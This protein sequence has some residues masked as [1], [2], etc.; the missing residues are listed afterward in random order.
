MPS[1]GVI[2]EKDTRPDVDSRSLPKGYGATMA[3]L[4]PRDPNW[5]FLYWEITAGAKARIQREN[6][7]DVF[8]K[9]KQV[10]RVYDLNPSEGSGGKY[11]DIPVMLD[12]GSWYV[13]VQDTGGSYCC[14]LGLVLP[15]GS[16]VGIVM[17]NPIKL[18]AGR[19]SDVTD[20]KWMAV[21]EDFDKLL[22]LSGV[23]YI[24]KG[25]G[26]VAK[27][28][29]QR[30]EM[31]LAVFSRAGSWGVSSMSSRAQHKPAEKKFR[32]AA[33]CELILYGATEPD[34]F[35]TV[36]GRR[37]KLNTDGTFSM[38]FALPDGNTDLPVKAMSKDETE[39]RQ[40]VISVTRMTA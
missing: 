7:Q 3:A 26:E 22:Q 39:S 13:Q 16:F 40:V 33:D 6:G 19:V 21:S 35:V 11:F 4:L 34:A 2:D 27:S 17:S 25:S 31:L 1:S 14:E 12:A 30:W 20:A 32:L 24:G 9:S 8:E 38:R 23:E 37:V 10:V 29:A 18:P 36:A 28:L 5:M 15:S